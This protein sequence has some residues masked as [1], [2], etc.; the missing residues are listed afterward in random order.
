M[1]H[2]ILT[3]DRMELITNQL[4]ANYITLKEAKNFYGV[5]GVSIEGRTKKVFIKNLIKATK[6]NE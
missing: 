5:Y 4:Q 6:E 2:W 3:W 1:K